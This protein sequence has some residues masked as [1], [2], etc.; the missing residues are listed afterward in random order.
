MFLPWIW[1]GGELMVNVWH[2]FWTVVSKL[3]R[4]GWKQHL[5]PLI[6]PPP[7]AGL[8]LNLWLRGNRFIPHDKSPK[9]DLLAARE[10]ELGPAQGLSHMF[11]VLQCGMDEYDNLVNVDPCHCALGLS[12]GTPR[13]SLEPRLGTA[14]GQK[15]M[16]LER[17]VS[18][19]P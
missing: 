3:E 17:A 2:V 9:I 10:L 19:V 15:W 6:C 13:T 8:H 5:L 16:P 7:E 4:V 14:W 1:K 11:L 18:K 12:K